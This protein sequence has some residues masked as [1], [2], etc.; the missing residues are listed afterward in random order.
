MGRQEKHAKNSSFPYV[1]II[2]IRFQGRSGAFLSAC[3]CKLPFILFLYYTA[4]FLFWQGLC[5]L[6]EK[7]ARPHGKA[8]NAALAF[9]FKDLAKRLH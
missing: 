2:Q 7:T 3:L 5:R 1:G 4:F 6:P 8:Q 9:L